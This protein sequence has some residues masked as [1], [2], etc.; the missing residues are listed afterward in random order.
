M[1][2]YDI[3]RQRQA[4]N[5]LLAFSQWP[6]LS[7]NDFMRDI[8]CVRI[9]TNRYI[10]CSVIKYVIICSYVLRQTTRFIYDLRL[11]TQVLQKFRH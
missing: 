3:V 7:Q 1:R 8:V 9:P 10:A 2:F 4:S 6:S 5:R 11:R